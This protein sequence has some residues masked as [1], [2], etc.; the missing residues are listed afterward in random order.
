MSWHRPRPGWF[1]DPDSKLNLQEKLVLWDFCDS[2]QLICR[3]QE[4]DSCGLKKEYCSLCFNIVCTDLQ[5][6][7]VNEHE[8]ISVGKLLKYCFIARQ[9]QI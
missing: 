8:R 2:N 5:L 1:R 7:V 6:V 9:N 3:C 4:V